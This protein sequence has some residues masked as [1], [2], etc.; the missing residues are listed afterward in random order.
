VGDT[1]SMTRAR[2]GLFGEKMIVSEI[3]MPLVAD[4][5][6]SVTARRSVYTGDDETVV[7]DL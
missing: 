1:V 5:S 3:R 6:M 7:I 4:D 2:L